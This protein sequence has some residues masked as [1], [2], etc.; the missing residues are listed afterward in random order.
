MA[1]GTSDA[2]QDA[3]EILDPESGEG[4]T[5][6]EFMTLLNPSERIII[7]QGLKEAFNVM[8]KINMDSRARAALEAECLQLGLPLDTEVEE[9]LEHGAKLA[10]HF[11]D[12]TKKQILKASEKVIVVSN[13]RKWP[14]PLS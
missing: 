12:L 6:S 4:P 2:L 9:V 1:Q 10:E 7:C 5:H 14:D 8:Q 3:N 13:R 11:E